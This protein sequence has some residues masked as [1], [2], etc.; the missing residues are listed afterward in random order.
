[1]CYLLFN[2]WQRCIPII[3]NRE[4]MF[5]HSRGYLLKVRPKWIEIL[6]YLHPFIQE[7]GV[8]ARLGTLRTVRNQLGDKRYIGKTEKGLQRNW[9]ETW[10]SLFSQLDR[11]ARLQCFKKFQSFFSFWIFSGEIKLYFT[12]YST[13][14]IKSLIIRL[15]VHVRNKTSISFFLSWIIL[16]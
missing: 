14:D 12:S 11:E 1:M 5:T 16:N 6:L 3:R 13:D 7:E 2:T 10:K 8:Y 4:G 9:Q 15:C